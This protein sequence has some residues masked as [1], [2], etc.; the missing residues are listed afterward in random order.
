MNITVMLPTRGRPAH[1]REAVGTLVRTAYRPDT[2]E[3][4]FRTDD[5]DRAVLNDYVGCGVS[6]REFR[7]VRHGYGAMH[8]YYN[9]LASAAYGRLLLLW[10]DDTEMLTKNWDRALIECADASKIPLVQFI[11]RSG[12]PK[13]DDTLPVID[14]RVIEAIGH[15][16]LHCYCD[17]WLSRVAEGAGLRVFREDIVFHHHRLDD[18]TQQDNAAAVH[19]GEGHRRW[20]EM[21]AERAA[22][23][24]KLKALT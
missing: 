6:V 24:Q 13:I 10:N 15:V 19:G 1:L 23:V 22:D 14:R 11:R 21:D 20:F 18:A 5:D 4:L 3:I 16:S 17:T 9:E 8:L 12:I 7:G 2:I